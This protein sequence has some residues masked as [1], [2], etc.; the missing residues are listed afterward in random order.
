MKFQ[1]P[2]VTMCRQ[3]DDRLGVRKKGNS[4]DTDPRSLSIR[5]TINWGSAE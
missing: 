5:G 3:R 4:Y 1:L 2:L